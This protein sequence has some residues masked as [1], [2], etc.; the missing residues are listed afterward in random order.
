M[1][2]WWRFIEVNQE[3]SPHWANEIMTREV[4]CISQV[5][6]TYS[7]INVSLS[8]MPVDIIWLYYISYCEVALGNYIIGKLH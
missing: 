1:I 5:N 6:T 8:P 2:F 7:F 4:F 3:Q